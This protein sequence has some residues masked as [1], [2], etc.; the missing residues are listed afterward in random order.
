[1]IDHSVFQKDLS[2]LSAALRQGLETQVFGSFAERNP[3]LGRMT[4]CPFC[5]TRHRQAA[6]LPCCNAA[7]ATTKR[8]WSKEKDFY[9]ESCE[10]RVVD[11]VLPKSIL[12]KFK[13]KRHSN[14]FRKLVHDMTLAM[15]DETARNTTQEQLEGLQ[16]FYSPQKSVPPQAVPAFA[17][18][19]V[20]SI[21]KHRSNQK[22]KQ[23]QQAR[24]I[25]FGMGK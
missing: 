13:H 22:R 3:A 12:K 5:R 23:Q 4:R 6:E 18:R 21:R 2:D 15:Q 11:A 17:E 24:K 16:G 19:V 7:H 25:N 8:A 10:P 14:K 1:M 9:Q 20:R